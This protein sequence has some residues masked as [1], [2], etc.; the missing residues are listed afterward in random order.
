MYN[1]ITHMPLEQKKNT[2]NQGYTVFFTSS[3]LLIVGLI[4]GSNT[5]HHLNNIFLLEKLLVRVVHVP[6]RERRC[7]F[8]AASATS[9]G[10]FKCASTISC[11]SSSSP[12]PF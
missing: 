1:G 3:I 5:I 8:W 10:G 9:H 12:L 6:T 4:R 11:Y 7:L 2:W